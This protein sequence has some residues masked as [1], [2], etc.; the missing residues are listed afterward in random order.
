M[1]FIKGVSSAGKLK[2]LMEDDIMK[3]FSLKEV[4]L[5]Y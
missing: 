2:I 5:L 4:Q 3:E 1:G